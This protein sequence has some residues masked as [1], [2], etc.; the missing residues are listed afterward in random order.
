MMWLVLDWNS[1]VLNFYKK[2]DAEISKDII[3][4]KRRKKKNILQMHIKPIGNFN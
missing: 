2:F 3:A 1:L 4:L